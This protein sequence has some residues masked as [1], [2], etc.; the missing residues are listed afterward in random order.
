MEL[1]KGID[2]ANAINEKL[3]KES[4]DMGGRV[5]KLAIIRVGERPDD[6]SYERGATKKMEKVGFA[7]ES[8]V[9]PETIE[10]EAFQKEFDTINDNPEID[11]IFA[12]DDSLAVI[13]LHIARQKGINI[14]KDLKIIGV[15]GTKQ[16]LGF[17]PELTTIQQPVKQ[18]AKVAVDKLI[19]LIEGKT[20]ESCMDLPV[21]LL[22]GQTT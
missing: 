1:L 21:K 20:A 16:I 3:I 5:P 4:A 17:V 22:E 14:P 6:M 10:N 7:C 2:V 13:A 9:F 11:G 18:I 8:F 12:G 15:D 19:D